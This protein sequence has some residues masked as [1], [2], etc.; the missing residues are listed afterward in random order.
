MSAYGTKRLNS[1]MN[2]LQR[3]RTVWS[4]LAL[5]AAQGAATLWVMEGFCPFQ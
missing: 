2:G 4:Y 5:G 1:D 3:E